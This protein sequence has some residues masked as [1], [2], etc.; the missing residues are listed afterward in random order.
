MI[1]GKWNSPNYFVY[2]AGHSELSSTGMH[3]VDYI[4]D[5]T[6]N[7]NDIDKYTRLFTT[8]NTFDCSPVEDKL[9]RVKEEYLFLNFI[10]TYRSVC[11]HN[12]RHMR[13]NA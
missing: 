5:H 8:Q 12:M 7:P 6:M 3:Q 11:E 9:K 10:W 13:I 2:C 1:D 4:S